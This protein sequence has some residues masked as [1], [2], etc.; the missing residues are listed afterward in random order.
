MTLAWVRVIEERPIS[1]AFAERVGCQHASPQVV[2]VK[3]RK[4]VWS[5]SHWNITLETLTKAAASV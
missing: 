3:D 4:A 1:L 2:L 5:D